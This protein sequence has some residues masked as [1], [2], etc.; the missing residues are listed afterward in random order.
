MIHDA[1]A[2]EVDDVSTRRWADVAK[3]MPF[4]GVKWVFPTA[5]LIPVTLNGGMRMT[6]WYDINDLNIDGIVDDR[7]QTLASAQYVADLVQT[8]VDEGVP[9]EKIIVGGFSQGG[10]V[11]L[12]AAL[13]SDKK[14]AGLLHSGMSTH[15]CLLNRRHVTARFKRTAAC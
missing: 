7:A 15:F 3:Q 10:V 6:G 9:P 2:C 1:T 5:P 12:T 4:E 11:A 13:R 14:L 8:A